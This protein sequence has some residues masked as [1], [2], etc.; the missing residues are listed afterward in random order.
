MGD[1]DGLRRAFSPDTIGLPT[2]LQLERVNR[3]VLFPFKPHMVPK[4]VQPLQILRRRLN[5]HTGGQRAREQ[6]GATV[7]RHKS[8]GRLTLDPIRNPPKPKR[9]KRKLPN[10]REAWGAYQ[11]GRTH[12]TI[13]VAKTSW[14][15]PFFVCVRAILHCLL[16]SCVCPLLS[17]LQHV[18]CPTRCFFW[19]DVGT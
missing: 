17:R 3:F 7:R 9:K 6:N 13:A 16:L 12:C 4:S 2:G 19:Q 11:P 5:R 8:L 1:P 10:S 15:A 18:S 14:T